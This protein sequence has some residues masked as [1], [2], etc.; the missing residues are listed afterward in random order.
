MRQT[1]FTYQQLFRV[2]RAFGFRRRPLKGDPPTRL[3]MHESGAFLT[4]PRFPR[5][6]RVWEYHLVMARIQLD[7]FGIADPKLF[8]KELQKAG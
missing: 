4:F 8:D 7:N 6:E 5:G 2:L 1:E 3:F